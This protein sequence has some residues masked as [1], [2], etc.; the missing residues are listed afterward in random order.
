MGVDYMLQHVPRMSL[1]SFFDRKITQQ[2][3]GEKMILNELDEKEKQD[4][5]CMIICVSIWT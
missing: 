5:A 1:S 2:I 4:A 3:E